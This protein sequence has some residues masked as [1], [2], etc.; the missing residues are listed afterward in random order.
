[1]HL[2]NFSLYAPNGNYMLAP[3]SD[4]LNVAIVN[5]KDK[6]EMALTLNGKKANLKRTDFL[7]I[8]SK[9]GIEEKTAGQMIAVFKKNMPKW[10]VL[11]NNSFL[12]EDMKEKYKC[13]ISERLQ[14]ICD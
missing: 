8:A 12:S 3:A 1:M 6:E 9:L 4:L 11:I 10:N 14:R 2:K 13:L 5:P 7:A